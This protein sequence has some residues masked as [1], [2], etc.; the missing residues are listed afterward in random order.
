MPRR[1]VTGTSGCVCDS[2]YG[3]DYDN[4]GPGLMANDGLKISVD[5]FGSSGT[6]EGGTSGRSC[7]V[8]DCLGGYTLI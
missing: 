7:P 2:F 5:L 3:E 8:G 4:V 1:L 6:L